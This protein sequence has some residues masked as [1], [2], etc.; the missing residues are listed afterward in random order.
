MTPHRFT[1]SA[2]IALAI[3]A[4]AAPTAAAP[5]A[6]AQNPDQAAPGP[7]IDTQRDLPSPHARDAAEGRGAFSAP[8]VV[9]IKVREPETASAGGIDWADAGIGAGGMLGLSL[10]GIG[11]ALLLVHRKQATP[12]LGAGTRAADRP[13]RRLSRQLRLA[14]SQP[15]GA[16][17]D[18]TYRPTTGPRRYAGLKSLHGSRAT[19]VCIR[20][21]GDTVPFQLR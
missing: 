15:S 20:R 16:A 19:S 1:R 9:V 13:A 14:S 2:A 18:R 6:A 10:L 4:V 11:G 21:A 8:D 3:A 17:Q 5:T 12:A 7:G